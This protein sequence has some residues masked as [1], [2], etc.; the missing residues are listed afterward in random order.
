M[1]KRKS[2]PKRQLTPGKTLQNK[3]TSFC[4]A[5]RL[6]GMLFDLLSSCALKAL[7]LGAITTNSGRFNSYIM[8]KLSLTEFNRLSSHDQEEIVRNGTFLA[9]REENGLIVRL[10]GLSEFYLEVF[11]DAN[12]NK[13]LK[14]KAFDN[15][16]YLMPYLAHI[17]FCLQ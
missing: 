10:Y 17:K 15:T 13:V 7:P 9:D 3:F 6:I 14:I 16:N 4:W 1:T 5:S 11:Y 8:C 12:D 2:S